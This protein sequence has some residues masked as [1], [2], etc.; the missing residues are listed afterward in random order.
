MKPELSC[1]H[2]QELQW[3]CDAC[4]WNRAAEA[5]CQIAVLCGH[6]NPGDGE[7]T[8]P[9]EIVEYVEQALKSRPTPSV[10]KVWTA[11]EI[12]SIW[13]NTTNKEFINLYISDW[14]RL[15][16]AINSRLKPEG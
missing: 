5:L 14:Q 7:G 13:Y 8:D 10:Q 16:D 2:G 4:M 12:A 6:E 3:N 15:A 9:E 11:E 1:P